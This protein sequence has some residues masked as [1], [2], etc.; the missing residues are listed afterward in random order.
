MCMCVQMDL[1][2]LVRD[3]QVCVTDAR[4]MV[5]LCV[6]GV[7]PRGRSTHAGCCGAVP[8]ASKQQVEESG[9]GS[10]PSLP[11]G[12]A[13]G[14]AAQNGLQVLLVGADLGE[15]AVEALDLQL[16]LLGLL[17]QQPQFPLQGPL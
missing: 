11:A 1:N 4:L 10:V 14:Q 8:R 9:P 17:L 13:L 3:T 12:T 16:L 2:T 7:Q 6:L 15:V 5:L